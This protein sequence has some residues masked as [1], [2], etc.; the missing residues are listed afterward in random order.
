MDTAMYFWVEDSN[1]LQSF[2]LSCVN[3]LPRNN[4]ISA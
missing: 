2:K 4:D 1:L 3:Y